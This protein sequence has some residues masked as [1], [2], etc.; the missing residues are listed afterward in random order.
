MILPAA[1]SQAMAAGEHAM[2][3]RDFGAKGD[4]RTKDHA[5]I[6]KAVD[7]CAARGGGTVLV[8]PGT[9]LCGTVELRSR[10][11][12]YLDAGAVIAGSPDADDYRKLLPGNNLHVGNPLQPH[13]RD[14]ALLAARKA[15]DVGIGGP[16]TVDARGHH[17]FDRDKTHSR[18]KF[19]V[20]PW[21]PGPTVMFLDCSDVRL[22]GFHIRDN[23]F[24]AV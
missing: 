21:R 1:A 13:N 5:A 20:K 24:F 2:N 11:R 15:T 16:G 12:L 22:D 17:F 6:Q 8:P 9:Y 10:T 3:V 4:G 18:G 19:A 23:P 14:Q 7:A